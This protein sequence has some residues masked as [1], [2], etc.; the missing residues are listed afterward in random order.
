MRLGRFGSLLGFAVQVIGGGVALRD[1]AAAMFGLILIL[2]GTAVLFAAFAHGLYSH[3]QR[4]WAWAKR[5]GAVQI[6]LLTGI[7]GTWLFATIGLGAVA[8]MIWN[9]GAFAIG[10]SA[11]VGDKDQGPLVWTT[12]LTMEGGPGVDR[13][14]SALRFRGTNSSQ[15]EVKLKSANIVSTL[16]GTQIDLEIEAENEFIPID[17]AALV[18]AGA[19]IVLKAKFGDP[20]PNLPG[21]VTGLELKD[22]VDTWRQFAL[23]IEDDTKK[24]RVIFNEGNIAPFFPGM[25]GPHVTRRAKTNGK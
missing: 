12:L 4:L 9:G 7:A 22:F 11:I 3:R 16:K 25:V 1:P 19:P 8:W 5:M 6:A 24:Y 21:K 2:I 20:H 17:D 18:P 14:V 10:Q 13:N 23:N 15:T